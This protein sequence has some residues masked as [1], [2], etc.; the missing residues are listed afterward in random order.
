MKIEMSEATVE[1]YVFVANSMLQT[2]RDQWC[3]FRNLPAYDANACA[4]DMISHGPASWAL[5]AV[6][7]PFFIG[8]FS[9]Q[10]PGV[11][12][13]WAAGTD[14]GWQNYGRE[15]TRFVRKQMDAVFG[16]GAHRIEITSLASRVEAGEWYRKGLGMQAEGVHRGYCGDGQ[17]AICY[18][19]FKEIAR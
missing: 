4:M 2:E 7:S 10:R 12:V 19:K 11:W 14:H 3:A 6:G 1:D 18:A 17:D 13:C 9:N 15:I 16:L 5:R 8:G